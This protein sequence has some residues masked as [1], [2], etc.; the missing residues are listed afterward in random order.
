LKKKTS[1]KLN[2]QDQFFI[3]IYLSKIYLTEIHFTKF[4]SFVSGSGFCCP[5][6]LDKN[7]G[8]GRRIERTGYY[9]SVLS[10]FFEKTSAED[11]V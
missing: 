2:K 5:S 1:S 11:F 6:N 4:I 7:E 10:L 8:I 3:D 9:V